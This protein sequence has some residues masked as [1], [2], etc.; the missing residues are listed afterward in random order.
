LDSADSEDLPSMFSLIVFLVHV[1]V[2]YIMAGVMWFVQ[3]AYYPNLAAVG[4]DA[5][6]HY[7]RE[8]VRRISR[9][10]WTLLT[11]ELVSGVLL[12][13]L[14]FESIPGVIPAV[15]LALIISIWWSTWFVQVPLHHKLEEAWDAQLHHRLVTS[16][17]FR[18]F[19]YTIRGL[20]VLYALWTV[21][22]G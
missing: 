20:V 2:T 9:P 17:W 10:A 5:F 6:V 19:V 1:V 16:N 13:M 8:H 11:L 15:N 18:T 21:A 12:A 7:Q 3:L 4:E 22:A 14:G